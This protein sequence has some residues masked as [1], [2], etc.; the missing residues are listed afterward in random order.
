M[1]YFYAGK[2]KL[3][4]LTS[5]PTTSYS[6]CSHSLVV[7]KDRA[8]ASGSKHQCNSCSTRQQTAMQFLQSQFSSQALSGQWIPH[9]PGSKWEAAGREET[10]GQQCLL[11]LR[12]FGNALFTY[13]YKC[14]KPF[15]LFVSFF[16]LDPRSQVV[17][18][19]GQF[20][21][22]SFSPAVLAPWLLNQTFLSAGV[23]YTCQWNTGCTLASL[24]A[25]FSPCVGFAWCSSVVHIM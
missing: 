22:C 3:I 19:H 20:L 9:L 11:S 7:P 6:G 18:P 16:W 21:A 14:P 12:T 23:S 8:A 2:I 17:I 10:R 13:L 15:C 24:V 4:P 25:K 5:F 1:G